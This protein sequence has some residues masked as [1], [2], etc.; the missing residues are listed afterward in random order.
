MAAMIARFEPLDTVDQAALAPWL[1][2]ELHN[3]NGITVGAVRPAA[4]LLN[5]AAH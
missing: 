1:Q 5:A 3:W 4:E 2:P